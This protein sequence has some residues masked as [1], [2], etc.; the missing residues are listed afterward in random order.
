[1]IDSIKSTDDI[2]NLA[3]SSNKKITDLTVCLLDRPRHKEIIQILK[4][5]FYL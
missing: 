1:M 2:K 5:M 3:D 4:Y